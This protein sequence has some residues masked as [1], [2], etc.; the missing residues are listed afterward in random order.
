MSIKWT[1]G[2]WQARHGGSSGT[3]PPH[4]VS[5]REDPTGERV[6][7]T[8]AVL[9][10]NSSIPLTEADANADLLAAAHLMAGYIKKRADAGDPE[11]A[12]IWRSLANAV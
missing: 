10:C 5:I 4:V 12:E 1:K 6:T 7:T 8:I 9:Q 3:P 2:E 11:A